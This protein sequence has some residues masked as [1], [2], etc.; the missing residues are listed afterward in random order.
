MTGSVVTSMVA[1]LLVAAL[2]SAGAS[3]M[4][5]AD[6]DKPALGP[7]FNGD[8]S[9]DLAVGVREEDLGSIENAGIVQVIYGTTGGLS[10]TINQVWSQDSAGVA[11]DPAEFEYFGEALGWGDYDGDEYDDLAIGVPHESTDP[12]GIVQAEI[13]DQG[14]VRMLAT[15]GHQTPNTPLHAEPLS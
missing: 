15:G 13:S 14:E 4:S 8:G 6:L 5:P 7:D 3:T 1:A 2:P 12:S 10:S 9:A 11:G